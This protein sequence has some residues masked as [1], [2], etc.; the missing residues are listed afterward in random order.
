MTRCT[1]KF[2]SCSP[3]KVSSCDTSDDALE[4][5]CCDAKNS[6]C[7]ES[8]NMYQCNDDSG[9]GCGWGDL[10]KGNCYVMPEGGGTDLIYKKNCPTNLS[11]KKDC[12][13]PLKDCNSDSDCC[14]NNC[15]K[16]FGRMVC[17]PS[18]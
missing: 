6:G 11:C 16:S 5:A 17:A 3:Q 15:I 10:Q 9:H 4:Q 8:L 2:G 7:L 13:P 18:P 12:L 1:D 14:N